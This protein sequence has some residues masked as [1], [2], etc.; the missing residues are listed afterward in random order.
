MT[1]NLQPLDAKI[2]LPGNKTRRSR[3]A[4]MEGG[5][6]LEKTPDVPSPAPVLLPLPVSPALAP[7]PA[8]APAPVPIPEPQTSSS[9]LSPAIIP[10]P[11]TPAIG[12]G[13]VNIK[14]K[15][16]SVM[17]GAK[18]LPKKKIATTFKKPKFVVSTLAPEIESRNALPGGTKKRRFSERSISIEM[19]PVSATRRHRKDLGAKIAAMPVPAIR[20]FL[21]RK[22]V[23]KPK[24]SVSV[25]E[26]ILRSMLKDY[27]L[28]HTAE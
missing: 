26:G 3:R 10:L 23:L 9:S 17:P 21:L 8:P 1:V 11:S 27:L 2:L 5:S 28:L 22:G 15:R 20:K 4:K 19:K 24:A 13:T 25:P 14:G 18:I 16:N 6:N 7:A 12:G